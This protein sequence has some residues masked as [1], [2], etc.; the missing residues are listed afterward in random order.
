MEL[1][2]SCWL[3]V[4]VA[5]VLAAASMRSPHSHSCCPL[6]AHAQRSGASDDSYVTTNA[7][8]SN[9]AH[10]HLNQNTAKLASQL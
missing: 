2:I 10:M 4:A 7:H 9:K 1:E 6:K 5:V 3:C 8:M